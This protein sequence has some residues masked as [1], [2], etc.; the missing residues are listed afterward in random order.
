MD[1]AILFRGLILLQIA[2]FFAQSY[3]VP[4]E[5]LS[6]AETIALFLSADA[7]EI[8]SLVYLAVWAF[9]LYLL[10]HF[11]PFSRA[12]YVA[13]IAVGIGLSFAAVGAERVETNSI[14][15]IAVW[16]SGALDGAILTMLYLTAIGDNFSNTKV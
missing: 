16:F 11:K 10:F 6:D 8:A 12:L 4:V 3:S 13:L 9:S 5:E 7:I 14:Y 15:D 2:A 1:L